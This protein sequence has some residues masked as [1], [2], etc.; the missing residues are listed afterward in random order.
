MLIPHRFNNIASGKPNLDRLVGLTSFGVKEQNTS[1]P[2]TSSLDSFVEHAFLQRCLPTSVSSERGS[3]VSSMAARQTTARDR[4]AS[5]TAA[6]HLNHLYSTET[7]YAAATFASRY[8][9]CGI[10]DSSAAD[11]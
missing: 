3:T 2:G 4:M 11:R 1:F 5:N 10:G 8:A 9:S 6:E 7:R